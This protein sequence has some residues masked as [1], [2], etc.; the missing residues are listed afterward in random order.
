MPLSTRAVS[1]RPDVAPLIC[2][3][4]CRVRAIASLR[5]REFLV[6]SLILA[7]HD[8]PSQSDHVAWKLQAAH[9]S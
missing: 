4:V 7:E 2:Q 8:S 6:N 5:V 1:L 3:C 9:L